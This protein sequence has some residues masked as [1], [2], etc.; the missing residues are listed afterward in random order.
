MISRIT[1]LTE[2]ITDF[3]RY[4]RSK[5]YDISAARE[6]L[7][8]EG[9]KVGHFD[10]A[11]FKLTLKSVFPTSHQNYQDFDQH[12]DLYFKERK[13][14]VDAKIKEQAKEVKKRTPQSEAS[15]KSLKNWLHGGKQEEDELAAYGGELRLTEKDLSGFTDEDLRASQE[16]IRQ[17]AR[18]IR[19]KPGRRNVFSKTATQPNLK[20]TL[21][22]NLKRGTE[23]NELVFT[24][25][26]PRAVRIVLLTD[27]SRSMEVY[28]RFF[29][30]F[31]HAFQQVYPRIDT[32]VFS[33]S[34]TKISEHIYRKDFKRAFANLGDYVPN[35]SG[36]TKIGKSLNEFVSQKINQRIDSKTIVIIVSDG[37]DT[38]EASLVSAAM[39]KIKTRAKKVVWVNPLAGNP[40]YQ[41]KAAAMQA[42]LPYI[43]VFSSGHN[44][45]S[46]KKLVLKDL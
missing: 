5:G 42:A 16:L 19:K 25:K 38:G 18:R 17:L 6:A 23:I 37:L 11:G 33:S 10:K 30:Q 27:V 40:E 3:G 15:F 7:A 26:K 14:G 34:L 13:K 29:V 21:R 46:L 22:K 2:Q 36:G 4:L 45:G 20:A 32:Y 12:F 28:S 44:L 31:M 43:D 24:R 35:W 1:S 9:L 41:P 8:L 39:R